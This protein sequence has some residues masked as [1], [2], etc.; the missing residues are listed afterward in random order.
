MVIL[1]LERDNQKYIQP[2][3]IEETVQRYLQIKGNLRD[4]EQKTRFLLN[5]EFMLI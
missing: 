4:N 5:N 1:S 3:N 2:I